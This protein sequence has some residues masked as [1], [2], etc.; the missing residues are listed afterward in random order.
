MSEEVASSSTVATT[1]SSEEE[2]VVSD[3]TELKGKVKEA[4]EEHDKLSAE[5]EKKQKEK[6]GLLKENEFLT[7]RRDD[8]LHKNWSGDTLFSS[9]YIMMRWNFLFAVVIIRFLEKIYCMKLFF[10]FYATGPVASFK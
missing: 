4:E 2:P 10:K 1:E 5:L 8:L 3:L 9:K 7:K 6:E